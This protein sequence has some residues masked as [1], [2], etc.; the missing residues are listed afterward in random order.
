MSNLYPT[1]LTGSRSTFIDQVRLVR[2][3][4]DVKTV[5]VDVIDGLVA[6]NLT[7]SPA[8][9]LDVEFYDL[10]LD[11]HLMVEEP[12]DYLYEI[13]EYQSHLPVRGVLGQLERM[14]NQREFIELTRGSKLWAGL[15]L[16]L[17]TPLEEIDQQ[18][19]SQLNLIQLMSV[20]MGF[21][22]QQFNSSIF[23]KLTQ[24]VQ[25]KREFGYPFEIVID[26]GVNKEN[27][28]QLLKT[29]ADSLAVGSW[30]WKNNNPQQVVEMITKALIQ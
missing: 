24:L 19:L 1:I 29:G 21:Q 7:L 22:G 20:E 4:P 8:D 27:F 13:L 28:L 25:L 17:F 9:L 30:L 15:S 3:F 5:Q 12:L 16:D 26:G 14:S 18:A 23:A 2:T 6:D 11:F 10:S